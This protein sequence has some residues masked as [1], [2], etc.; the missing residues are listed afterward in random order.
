MGMI[1]FCDGTIRIYLCQNLTRRSLLHVINKYA[2]WMHVAYCMPVTLQWNHQNISTM[3]LRGQSLRVARHLDEWLDSV[4][5]PEVVH[6]QLHT[7]S[8]VCSTVVPWLISLLVHSICG[9]FLKKNK[10]MVI[11]YQLFISYRIR[12]KFLLWALKRSQDLMAF[13]F[14]LFSRHRDGERWSQRT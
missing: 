3:H 8:S 2:V 9:Y 7:Q 11:I 12:Y 13:C 14:S 6:T 5:C 10:K 1:L 4:V